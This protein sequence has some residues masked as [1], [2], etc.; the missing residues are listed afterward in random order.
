MVKDVR[1]DRR[2]NEPAPAGG[3]PL[4]VLEKRDE[5]TTITDVAK[6]A[7]VSRST[8]SYVLSGK[9]TISQETRDRV[10]AVIDQLGF[11]VRSSARALATSRTMSI[12]VV[13]QFHRAEFQPALTTYL[14]ALADAARDA[15]FG[16]Q[17]LTDSDGVEAVRHAIGGRQV[18]GL[19]LLNVVA[20]DPRVDVVEEAGFP[21]VLIGMVDGSGL[22]A[23][24]LDFASGAQMLVNHLYDKGHREVTFV[25]WPR[26]VYRAGNTFAVRFERTAH[27]RARRLGMQLVDHFCPPEPAQIREDLRVLLE[28][29]PPRALLVHNDGA[30]AM[31]PTVLH[32]LGLA[33]PEDLSVVSLHSAE[34]TDFFAL[35][36]T[37]V[38]S[39]PELVAQSAV[40]LLVRTL[41][42][43]PTSETAHMLVPP[44]LI[45]RG[46][47]AGVE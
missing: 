36:F 40:R 35:P 21:A 3:A 28:D 12:G 46:S 14:V 24:D 2:H 10:Q 34:L 41:T 44:T 25:R 38:E 33:A 1:D 9:R 11:S 29:T 45:D 13:V 6:A 27:A 23:V 43:D 5:M 20:D 16:L 37:S 22:D 17:L 32:G 19:V 18:D 42:E 4:S 26:E 39:A 30:V 31:L 47:V 15:G 8:V 7:G